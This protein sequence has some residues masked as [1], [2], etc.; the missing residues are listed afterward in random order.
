MAIG[1]QCSLGTQS[2]DQDLKAGTAL[3]YIPA[4][5]E[6]NPDNFETAELLKKLTVA[7][8]IG[9][10]ASHVTS[11]NRAI[12]GEVPRSCR[13]KIKSSTSRSPV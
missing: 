4:D 9:L 8:L 10:A 3:A 12:D 7:C 13:K 5:I 1:V 6:M 11:A 2:A